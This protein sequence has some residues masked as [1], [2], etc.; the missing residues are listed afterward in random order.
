[1]KEYFYTKDND[2]YIIDDKE[3]LLVRENKDNIEETLIVE[4]NIEQIDNKL[5]DI[6]KD[7]I[8]NKFSSRMFV[9]SSTAMTIICLLMVYLVATS[10]PLFGIDL[11]A[12]LPALGLVGFMGFQIYDRIENK[13]I[14]KG[15]EVFIKE[16]ENDLEKEKKKL[17]QLELEGKSSTTDYT[18]IK[19]IPKTE[20]VANLTRKKEI[21]FDYMKKKK[22]Y[23]SLYQNG[24]LDS[25]LQSKNYSESDIEL[26]KTIMQEEIKQEEINK[27]SKQKIK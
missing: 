11:L 2:A 9:I 8:A 18:K 3:G 25:F 26:V 20:I 7:K 1:M 14:M 15:F 12:S 19:E 27:K 13:K 24:T 21:I 16:M 6:K 4:N 17:E 10:G 23:N 22:K 5:E